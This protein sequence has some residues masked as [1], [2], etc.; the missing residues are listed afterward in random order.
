MD[1]QIIKVRN[2]RSFG[3]EAQGFNTIKPINILIGKNNSGKSALIDVIEA[4]ANPDSLV[5]K[6][7][8]SKTEILIGGQMQEGMIN[9][10]FPAN[11]S[12]SDVPGANYNEYGMRLK[13][14]KAL[15]KLGV[16]GSKTLESI[17]FD[18]SG[19]SDAKRNEF[20]QK[21]AGALP[22]PL[23]NCSVL[24]ILAE[25]D[26]TSEKPVTSNDVQPNGVGAT[27]I[28]RKHINDR[29]LP[30][31]LVDVQILNGLN[32][33][34]ADDGHFEKI[35]V[36]ED[37]QAGDANSSTWEIY[38]DETNK[39]SI[40]LS[41]S[42]S[43]LKTVLLVLINLH[44]L[45]GGR[46]LENFIFA[47]EELENNLH[48]GVLRRL[49]L[50]IEEFAKEHKSLFFITT[51][52]SVVIDMFSASKDAQ[53]LHVTNDGQ[54]SKVDD[55]L[56]FTHKDK[57]FSDLDIRAS[58]LLQSNVIIWVEGPS[59]RIYINAWIDWCSSGAIREGAHYQCVFYGG[60]TLSHLESRDNNEIQAGI[61]VLRVNRHSILMMDSDLVD[62]TGVINSTKTRIK[63][64]IEGDGGLVWVTKGKE[65]ENYLPEEA[66][67][68]VFEKPSLPQIGQT[69]KISDYLTTNIDSSAAEKFST[70]KV[71]YASEFVATSDYAEF[72]K[73][74]D[75]DDRLKD[76][77]NKIAEWNKMSVTLS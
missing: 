15:V 40:K 13:D 77:V 51:H 72:R 22:N 10:V 29:T 2:Y 20:T 71:K 54:A 75:L 63:G 58:D 48:P 35:R 7:D 53:L 36:Q 56:N 39:G 65:V 46:A 76:V 43:G 70:H 52:S 62:T 49:Y 18:F 37:S 67:R 26:I 4:R 64:E 17:D 1:G 31:N 21:I 69:E 60:R 66:L 33:I 14:K 28:I 30:N 8:A 11:T 19:I 9:V 42:G 25:R 24:R 59:D 5:D 34:F 6:Q 68:R 45:V 44:I 57:I 50:Y 38:L 55:V 41:S 61:N 27:N 12:S 3:Q 73:V 74:L 16:G 32:E 23:Q 47:F